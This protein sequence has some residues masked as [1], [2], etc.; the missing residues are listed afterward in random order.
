M[1]DT[2]PCLTCRQSPLLPL[3]ADFAHEVRARS[4][5]L[6]QNFVAA[7]AVKAHGRGRDEYARLLVQLRKRLRQQPRSLDAT[8]HDAALLLFVPTPFRNRLARE[9]YG[10]VVTFE[11]A[12]IDG[13]GLGVPLDGRT[14][15]RAKLLR[16]A[17]H[18][19]RH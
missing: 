2:Y 12:R 7:F 18:E 5:L 19:P 15:R 10:G 4:A 11:R 3:A 1:R 14:R 8:I 6:T 16:A 17:A 13:S 9:M